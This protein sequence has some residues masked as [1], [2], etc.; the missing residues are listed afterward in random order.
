MVA[1]RCTAP[2]SDTIE[3]NIR[4]LR[5]THSAGGGGQGGEGLPSAKDIVR[6]AVEE[7]A[8]VAA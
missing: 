6:Y 2:C 4:E 1:W 3:A 5:S 8:Q 7:A